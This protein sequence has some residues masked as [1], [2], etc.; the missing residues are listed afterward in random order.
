MG[1]AGKTVSPL[2]LR[3]S[4]LQIAKGAVRR[5]N[6]LY[7]YPGDSDKPLRDLWQ[8]EEE[9]LVEPPSLLLGAKCGR[10]ESAEAKTRAWLRGSDS[11]VSSPPASHV[12]R[13]IIYSIVN[14]A[15]RHASLLI[16][17]GRIRAHVRS[18]HA[19]DAALT[20]H[21]KYP[22]PKS[23]PSVQLYDLFILLSITSL[24]PLLSS[25]NSLKPWIFSGRPSCFAYG[26]FY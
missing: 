11:A 26:L 5:A 16:C 14:M 6:V 22:Y 23:P 10:Q 15:I 21:N 13:L 19:P 4:L 2:W 24:C 18:T 17:G 3:H 1:T 9:K 7:T 8:W 12:H 25:I 20:T